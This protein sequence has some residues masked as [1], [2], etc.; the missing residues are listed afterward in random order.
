[1]PQ[2]LKEE[3][4]Y[5]IIKAARN[6][7]YEKGYRSASIKEIAE[8]AGIPAGLVYS[9]FS[10]KKDLFNKV[11]QPVLDLL[12]ETILHEL[13]ER[14]EQNLYDRELPAILKCIEFYR[15]EIVIL[16]DK[17]EGSEMQ[18]VKEDIIRDVTHH[19]RITPFLSGTDF[20]EIFYHILATNFMEGIF[21][22]ARHYK[23][24]PWAE[25]ILNLLI[26]QHLYG[27]RVFSDE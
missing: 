3:I 13:P 12:N 15:K 16:I 23:D 19:L 5:R 22:I 14:P 24:K 4:R 21:E 26:R 6:A 1:M 2:V 27:S 10:S 25:K 11:V 17:S 9:Y 18:A 7:F 20:D 8:A